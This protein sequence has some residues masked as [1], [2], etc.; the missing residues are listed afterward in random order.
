MGARDKADAVLCHD[1][2]FETEG[3]RYGHRAYQWPDLQGWDEFW[4]QRAEDWGARVFATF[5]E[6]ERWVNARP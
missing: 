4:G 6:A 5:A 2:V 3:G 1:E